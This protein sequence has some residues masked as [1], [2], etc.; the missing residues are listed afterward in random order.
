MVLYYIVLFIVLLYVIIY[1]NIIQTFTNSE[2]PCRS[3]LTDTQYLTHM[4]SHHQIAIDISEKYQSLAKSSILKSIIRQLIWTQKYEIALMKEVLH[5]PIDNVSIITHNTAYVPTVIGTTFPNKKDLTKT[6]CDP[7]FF[8]INSH[9]NHM[10]T[11]A[12][13]DK[14]YISHMI[15][16]HQVAID[17]SKILLL[18]T[19][20]DFMTGLAYRIIRDQEGEVLRLHN[21]MISSLNII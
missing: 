18:H 12:M 21:L 7:N 16:H 8:D 19:K 4:I 3:I 14:S 13:T 10:N 15:P 9:T 11:T 5:H 17:M 6:Y 20:S 1:G 2:Y